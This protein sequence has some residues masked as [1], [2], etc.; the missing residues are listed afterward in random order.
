MSATELHRRTG[1]VLRLVRTGKTVNVPLGRY[2]EV[3][4]DMVRPERI[5]A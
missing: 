1:E 4:A 2:A 5:G 3:Q